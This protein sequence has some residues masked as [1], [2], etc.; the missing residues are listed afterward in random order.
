MTETPTFTRETPNFVT[1]VSDNNETVK[2]YPDHPDGGSRGLIRHQY[3]GY[4]AHG[5]VVYDVT[6]FEITDVSIPD[7]ELPDGTTETEMLERYR[8][9]YCEWVNTDVF[10]DEPSEWIE[11]VSKHTFTVKNPYEGDVITVELKTDNKRRLR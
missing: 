2:L 10:G 5:V 6:G 1:E 4:P 9:D 11:Y 8:D 7:K 3:S